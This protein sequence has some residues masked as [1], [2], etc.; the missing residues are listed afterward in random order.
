MFAKN[1][2][3]LDSERDATKVDW[4]VVGA[5]CAAL[6]LVSMMMVA[7]SMRNDSMEAQADVLSQEF[8]AEFDNALVFEAP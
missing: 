3:R 5:T 4:V 1:R 7:G 8:E 6:G 2:K